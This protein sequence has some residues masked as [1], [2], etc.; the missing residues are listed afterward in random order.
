MIERILRVTACALFMAAATTDL[1]TAARAAGLFEPATKADEATAKQRARVDRQAVRSRIVPVN[2]GELSRHVAPAG[3]DTA[4]NRI[5][6]A[7]RLDGIIR[8]E[9]FPDAIAT[10]RRTNVQTKPDGGYI[11]EGDSDQ[12]LSD[13]LLIV[14]GGAVSGR[15]QLGNRLFR[16]DHVAGRLHRVTELNAAA[17]PPEARPLVAPAVPGKLHARP[18]QVEPQAVV[19]VRVLVAYT[20]DAADTSP[21]SIGQ[22]INRAIALSNQAYRRGN[23]PMVLQLAARMRVPGYDE[24]NNFS[25]NLNDLTSGT[26]FRRVRSRRNTLDADLVSLFRRDGG[27]C[28]IAWVPPGSPMPTPAPGTRDSG[29]S[30][31]AR[32]CVD[33]LSFHHELGHN[34]GLY[35]D[36]FVSDPA[37]DSVYNYGYVNLSS[38]IR[39]VMAYNDRCAP[40]FCTRVN[41][42]S[43]PTIRA[44]PG[45][46]VIGV[47]QGNPGAADNTRR[48]KTTRV[49][50]SNY[51]PPPADELASAER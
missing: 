7:R 13:A 19:T 51:R 35:H 16:I 8:I 25:Q 49:A 18:D 9:L 14:Q 3:I 40:D 23:I 10:F 48:L 21:T 6:I 42:L 44:R 37:P 26:A 1:G 34:M 24:G 50:I 15:V 33:N 27:F 39:T 29:F 32:N 5:A 31:V 17:F 11:W 28:G 30:V 47:S 20:D 45:N 22:E 38:R 2:S 46:V 43:S 12:S 41:Y 36:R 4:P